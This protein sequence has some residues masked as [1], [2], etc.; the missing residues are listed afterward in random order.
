MLKKR[1]LEQEKKSRAQYKCPEVLKHYIAE[2]N[3]VAPDIDLPEPLVVLQKYANR[4]AIPKSYALTFDECFRHFSDS[5]KRKVLETI[6]FNIVQPSL[7]GKEKKELIRLT[8]LHAIVFYYRN[9]YTWRINLRKIA[10][11]FWHLRNDFLYAHEHQLITKSGEIVEL[12]HLTIQLTRDGEIGKMPGQPFE[13]FH[14]L[15]LDRIRACEVC[16]RIFWAK[17]EDKKTCSAP[18]LNVFNVRRYR[19]YSEEKKAEIKERRKAN[20]K[21]KQNP[22]VR[23]K[24]NGNL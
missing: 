10:K 7:P 24:K 21:L 4:Y 9:V 3:A 17:R 12:P 16:N 19:S 15:N 13:A 20:E 23:K 1:R 6:F 2:V 14:G 11:F 5:D 22:K 18:C 8:L